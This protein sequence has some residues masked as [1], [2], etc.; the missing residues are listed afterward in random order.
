M[1]IAVCHGKRHIIGKPHVVCSICIENYSVYAE[2]GDPFYAVVK[3]YYEY[4][5]KKK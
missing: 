5:P 1:Y 3:D 4:K 2:R